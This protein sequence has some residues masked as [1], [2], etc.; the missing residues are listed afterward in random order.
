MA[1]VAEHM[2]RE[3]VSVGPDE[4]L[5]AAAQA[6]DSRHVGA[7]IVLDGGRL[8]GIL[9]ERDVLRAVAAGAALP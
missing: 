3:L 8:L 9:T 6:M 4:Q 7:A 1:T 2:A 5:S